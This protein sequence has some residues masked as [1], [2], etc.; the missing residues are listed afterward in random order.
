MQRDI[1]LICLCERQRERKRM[2]GAAKCNALL[3]ETL[4]SS[5]NQKHC[6]S[7]GKVSYCNQF[8]VVIQ[9]SR[10]LY[11][12]NDVFFLLVFIM[13]KSLKLTT[14]SYYKN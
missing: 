6:A 8:H 7:V 10:F 4:F 5:Q 12:T 14:Y 9:I 13:L 11:E 1:E 2:N 3:T